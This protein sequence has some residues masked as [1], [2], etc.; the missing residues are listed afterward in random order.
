MVHT[1]LSDGSEDDDD[2]ALD[3]EA[4]VSSKKTFRKAYS[5]YFC[6]CVKQLPFLPL[7]HELRILQRFVSLGLAHLLQRQQTL[8]P[9]CEE[10][11]IALGSSCV[12]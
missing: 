7:N 3:G 11:T 10:L 12:Y 4:E 9:R 5:P 6:W 8:V 1:Y 2:G